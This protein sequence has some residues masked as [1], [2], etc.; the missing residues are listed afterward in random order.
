VNAVRWANIHAQ[1]VLNAL[2]GNYVR[3]DRV[4]PFLN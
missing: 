3:H 4:S 2:V 1:F